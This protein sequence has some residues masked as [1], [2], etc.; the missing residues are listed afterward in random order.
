MPELY[1]QKLVVKGT[2]SPVFEVYDIDEIFEED[3]GY[4]YIELK[5]AVNTEEFINFES[6]K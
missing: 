6:N 1:G 3:N 4:S 5:V 2:D